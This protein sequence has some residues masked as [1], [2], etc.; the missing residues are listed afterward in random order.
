VILSGGQISELRPI[1]HGCRAL[2]FALARLSCLIHFTESPS[3]NLV[4]DDDDS[5]AAHHVSATV[6][7]TV[8]STI[9]HF[10]CMLPEK[11]HNSSGG[12]LGLL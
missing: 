6:S 10:S 1:Y 4:D 3:L 7:A 12:N 2:T 11:L 5:D 9:S 8:P